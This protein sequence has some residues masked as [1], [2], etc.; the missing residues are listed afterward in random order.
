M[1]DWASGK[2]YNLSVVILYL[3]FLWGNVDVVEWGEFV[4]IMEVLHVFWV[5]VVRAPCISDGEFVEPQHVHHSNLWLHTCPCYF[6]THIHI[7]ILGYLHSFIFLLLHIITYPTK[8]SL[9]SAL[10]SS[11]IANLSYDGTK[12][13]W[14]LVHTS[15]NQQTTIWP[16]LDDDSAGLGVALLYEVFGSWLEIIEDVLLVEES[17]RI[18]PALPVFSRRESRM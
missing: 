11:D 12:Q 13:I 10:Y 7:D 16:S 17:A 4:H 2:L 18:V 8:N 9:Y 5:A 15:P 3:Y 1:R 6:T 14:S